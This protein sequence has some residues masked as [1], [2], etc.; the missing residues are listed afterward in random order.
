MERAPYFFLAYA[1][2]PERPWVNKFYSALSKEILENT[3]W[4]TEYPVG[5]M[6]ES[7]IRLGEDWR[8]AVAGALA[9]CRV[10]VPLYSRRYFSRPQCGT[11]WHA[12]N[13]RLDDHRDRHGFQSTAIVPAL[14]TPVAEEYIPEAVKNVQVDF[15]RVHTSY[16][17]EGLYTLIKNRAYRP[18]YQKVVTHLARQIIQAAE[19]QALVP[20]GVNEIDLS[21]DA[22]QPSSISAP[23][24]R[25]VTIM[26][27]APTTHRLPPERSSRSYGL[28]A[29]AW[30]PYQPESLR[31]I[32]EAVAFIARS[33]DYEPSIMSLDEGLSGRDWMSPDSG[34]GIVLFDPW[35]CLDPASAEQIRRADELGADRIGT[36]VIWNLRD[37]QTQ[38]QATRIRR[39]L[40]QTAPR[41]LGDPNI[42]ATL[43]AAR[44]HSLEELNSQIPTVLD[45]ALNRYLNH[46]NAGPPPGTQTER[47]YLSGPGHDPPTTGPQQTGGSDG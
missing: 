21:R 10:L 9:T 43:G 11:E 41:L 13:R 33:L 38:E 36:V 15:Q 2:T 12:F 37:Q 45:R 14:W 22:F 46:A 26:V 30:A 7:G 42:P 32:A 6:D 23:A 4:P 28:A 29:T 1:H 25:R 40:Y 3:D 8:D 20:C 39:A 44:V 47:P 31:P 18:I 27:A 19:N 16:A 24:T 17:S 35:L 34:L 5:F